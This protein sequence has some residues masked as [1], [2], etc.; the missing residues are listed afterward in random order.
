MSP[1]IACLVFA[2]L[3]IGF[4]VLDREADS[5]HSTFL[6]IPC[7]YLFI[8]TSRPVSVWFNAAPAADSPDFYLEGSPLDRLVVSVLLTI[9]VAV[10][11]ARRRKV[12]ILLSLNW[13]VLVFVAYCA[14][15]ICWSDYPSI[16]L[17]RWVKSLSDIVMLLVVLT[18]PDPSGAIKRMF[19]RLG[20]VLVVFSVCFIKYFPALGRYYEKW[21]GTQFYCGVATDKN[22]LGMIC[23]ISGLASVWRCTQEY[24]KPRRNRNNR[25]LLAQGSLL[26][27]I[28]WL[29]LKANSVTSSACFVL[30][31]GL[32][33]ICG[34]GL[35]RKQKSVNLL[36]LATLT[37]AFSVL[38]LNVGG[39]ILEAMGRNPTLTG[40]TELWSQ[41]LLLQGHPLVGTG[42]ESFWLGDRLEHLWSRYWWHP[43]ESHNGYLEIYL[44]LGWIGIALLGI[45]IARGYQYVSRALRLNTDSGSLKLGFLVAALAYNFTEAAFK[46]MNPVWIA[47][48]LATL[49]YPTFAR[50]DTATRFSGKPR[51]EVAEEVFAES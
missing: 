40:R 46:A 14:I 23:F 12:T 13:P 31:G 15:S 11:I 21:E 32:I 28:V 43:N 18:E 1:T 48:L 49:D 39:V 9:G 27:L 2:L 7:F 38:F 42:F 41:V 30:G 22:M 25:V 37:F 26:A 45:L 16:A 51:E 19:S 35:I 6:W 4:L 34:K 36:V 3:T 47:F 8:C 33:V 50:V 29:L 17:K 44:N 20:F 10:L 5:G 24:V